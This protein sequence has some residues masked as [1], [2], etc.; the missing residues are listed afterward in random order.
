MNKITVLIGAL[1]V[2]FSS[3]GQ[4]SNPYPTTGSLGLGTA[5]PAAGYQ[6]QIHG[7][8]T[9][10]NPTT[11]Y[12]DFTDMGIVA[13]IP[14]TAQGITSRM[15]FTNPTTGATANDGTI[16]R[17]SGKNFVLQNVENE[18][19]SFQSN[20]ALINLDGVNNRISIGATTQYTGTSNA[21]LNINQLG[22]NGL[23]VMAGAGGKYGLSVTATNTDYATLIYSF[24]N[25]AL[26]TFSTKG[27]G[28]TELYYRYAGGTA[29]NLF[30]IRNN[31]RKILQV[32]ND[33]ILRSREIIVDALNWADYVFD[34][35]YQ[36][37][38]LDS[39]QTYIEENNHLPNVPSTEEV[40][41]QGVNVA[42]TDAI[43]LE[44]IEELTLYILQQQ[45][46]LKTLEE[47]IEALKSINK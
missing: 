44:K 24:T 41:Q 14:G 5:T 23:K 16:L 20:R 30:T 21:A 27:N 2:S 17:Q 9:Y 29:V 32:S 46:M 35:N 40:S 18:L 43:L 7:V 8:S 6:L 33:G 12:Y 15:G 31:D 26:P 1:C 42:K 19:L 3:I 22:D 4:N 36:L 45:E 38:S 10:T 13:T 39:L 11:Y 25:T 37:M 34:P 28:I 47:E